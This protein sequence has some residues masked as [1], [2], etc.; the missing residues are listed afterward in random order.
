MRNQPSPADPAPVI[1][2]TRE[3]RDAI[4]R[5][6]NLDISLS[7]DLE[8]YVNDEDKRESREIVWRLQMCLR[9]MDQLGW[10]EHDSRATYRVVVDADMAR[11]MEVIADRAHGG[12]V[13]NRKLLYSEHRQDDLQA[14]RG[15]IDEELDAL[16]AARRAR[17]V[18]AG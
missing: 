6:I 18:V 5:H 7:A 4:W 12:L 15:W 9:L 14:V 11:F 1:A 10:R 16:D 3:H 13:D 2:L 17:A 8:Y